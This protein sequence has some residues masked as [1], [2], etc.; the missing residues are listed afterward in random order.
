MRGGSQIRLSKAVGLF[1]L[2][3][4]TWAGHNMEHELSTGL[5]AVDARNSRTATRS[6]YLVGA[7]ERGQ[8]SDDLPRQLLI[9][10]GFL[11]NE[12]VFRLLRELAGGDSIASHRGRPR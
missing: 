12:C 4:P 10:K 5:R 3:W 8:Q 2:H 7:I 9:G 1:H 11:H 6:S